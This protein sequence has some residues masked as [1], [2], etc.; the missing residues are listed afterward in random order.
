MTDLSLI[1]TP[2]QWDGM[3]RHVD[4]EAPLEA[5]GLLG[6][7]SGVVEI[8]LPVKNVAASPVRFRMDPQA[9]L[10]AFAE[11]EAA[12]LELLAIFHSHPTGPSIP[13]PTDIAEAAYDAIYIIWSPVDEVPTTSSGRAAGAIWQARGFLINAKRVVEIPLNL[14]G[15]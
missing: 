9:Q 3:R 15:V 4:G 13:S 2:D 6:G 1:L 8:V 10:K 11:L 12:G 7:R 14:Q 5:C